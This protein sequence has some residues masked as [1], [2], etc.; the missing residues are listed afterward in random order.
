[1]SDVPKNSWTREGHWHKRGKIHSPEQEE[2]A[3]EIVTSNPVGSM[4]NGKAETRQR[5]EPKRTV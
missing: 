3:Q 2:E 1:V 5:K 4:T